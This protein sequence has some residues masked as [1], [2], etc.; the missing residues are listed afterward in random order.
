M[1]QQRFLFQ[2]SVLF[3]DDQTHFEN[4]IRKGLLNLPAEYEFCPS[5][6]SVAYERLQGR[7]PDLIVSTLEFKE[8]SILD[9]IRKTHGFLE[10]VPSLYLSEPH[11]ADIEAEMALLGRFEVMGRKEGPLALIRKM[12]Q[13]ISENLN[14]ER[15]PRFRPETQ[16]QESGSIL[17]P[18]GLL[19]SPWADAILKKNK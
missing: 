5:R 19:D 15:P 11:L 18:E 7:T 9:L 16:E 1:S 3:I 14:K 6:F 4:F 12:A 13:V 17:Q 8:G 2:Q 10:K